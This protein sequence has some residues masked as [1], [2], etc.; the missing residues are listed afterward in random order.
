MAA[1]PLLVGFGTHPQVRIKNFIFSQKKGKRNLP[2]ELKFRVQSLIR[3]SLEF[4]LAQGHHLSEFVI[5]NATEMSSEV[6]RKHIV[7]YVNDFSL[8]LGEQ[9]RGAIK[10][11]VQVHSS[12]NKLPVALD[13]MFLK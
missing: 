7:L 10:K 1:G 11:F 4:S 2:G 6:M 3:K 12:I 5:T 9:G 8:D 13:E